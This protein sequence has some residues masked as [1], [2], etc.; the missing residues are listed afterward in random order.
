[1]FFRRMILGRKRHQPPVVEQFTDLA[2][3]EPLIEP[4]GKT[5]DPAGRRIMQV[6]TAKLGQIVC[7]AAAADDQNAVIPQRCQRV[8]EAK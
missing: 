6:M 5:V 4:V 2:T 7:E 1:M 3:Y 8:A